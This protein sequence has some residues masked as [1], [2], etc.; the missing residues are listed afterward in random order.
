VSW[1]AVDWG[2]ALLWGFFATLVLTLVMSA[3]QGLGLS[4]ISMPFLIGS[5]FTPD[6]NRAIVIGSAVHFVN[7]WLISLVYA[8]V[9]AR[10]GRAT[11]WIGALLGLLQGL[12]VIVALLPLLPSLH[13]RMATEDY[14][15]TPTRQLEPPGFLGLNY[16]RRTP[17]ITLVAH[18]GYGILLGALD[19]VR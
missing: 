16:G 8:L 18:L 12:A 4:R 9:F 11:W 2:G 15:P 3:A 13:P 6:R 17:L 14:G 7:G 5:I 19:G 10:L 1:G